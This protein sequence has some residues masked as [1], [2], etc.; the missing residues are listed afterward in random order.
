MSGSSLPVAGLAEVIARPRFHAVL[1]LSSNDP[2]RTEIRLLAEI[3]DPPRLPEPVSRDPAEDAVLAL[4]AARLD[5]VVSG[6][7]DLLILGTHAGIPIAG[8][9]EAL[10]R[11]GG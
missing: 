4:A 5:L 3:A 2:G 1:V 8:P 11:I 10:A 7:H 9:A 6:D